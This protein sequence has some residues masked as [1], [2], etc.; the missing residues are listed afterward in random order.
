MADSSP[1]EADPK[2]VLLAAGAMTAVGVVVLFMDGGFEIS[3]IVFGLAVLMFV[4]AAV[5]WKRDA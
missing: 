3:L 4:L 2:D 1:L 5:Q